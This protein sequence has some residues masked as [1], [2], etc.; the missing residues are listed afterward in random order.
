MGGSVLIYALTRIE[1]MECSKLPASYLSSEATTLYQALIQEDLRVLW[2][3]RHTE[4]DTQIH[5]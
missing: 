5:I 1:C 2:L 4:T 3:H